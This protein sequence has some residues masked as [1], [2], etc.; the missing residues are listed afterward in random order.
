MQAQQDLEAQQA[1]LESLWQR[2]LNVAVSAACGDLK[3]QHEARLLERAAH[4]GALHAGKLGSMR[5]AQLLQRQQLQGKLDEALQRHLAQLQ[6]ERSSASLKEELLIEKYAA[7]LQLVAGEHA[8]SVLKAAAEAEEHLQACLQKVSKLCSRQFFHSFLQGRHTHTVLEGGYV[9]FSLAA[10]LLS[11][12]VHLHLSTTRALTY[13][14]TCRQKRDIPGSWKHRQSSTW[15]SWLRC[16]AAVQLSLRRPKSA[17]RR[18]HRSGR[19]A[20]TMWRPRC[21]TVSRPRLPS[22]VPM[23]RRWAK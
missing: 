19:I 12:L 5:D 10:A 17:C 16:R 9:G 13:I 21:R 1:D 8:D 3:Q 6:E 22:G 20:A 4:L 18:R 11:C 15:P 23:R 2:K 14:I 7:A